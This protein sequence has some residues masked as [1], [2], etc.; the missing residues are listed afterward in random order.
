MTR[1]FSSN[2]DL[3]QFINFLIQELKKI[4]EDHWTSEFKNALSISVMPGELLGA[5]RLTL[6]KFQKTDFPKKLKVDKD[7]REAIK[8]LDKALGYWRPN[9]L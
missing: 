4:N 3:F 8:E 9:N 1:K 2:S 7:I 6:L 5:L